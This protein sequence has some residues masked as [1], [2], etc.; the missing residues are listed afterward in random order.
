MDARLLRWRI[1]VR[2]LGRRF[3]CVGFWRRTGLRIVDRT[4]VG[5]FGIL[6]RLTVWRGLLDWIFLRIVGR[7]DL[8]IF[9]GLAQR[10]ISTSGMVLG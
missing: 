4:A 6:D 1:A 2:G 7:L 8:R 5:R 10:H 3:G 9:V